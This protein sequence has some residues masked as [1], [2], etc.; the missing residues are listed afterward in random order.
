MAKV[1]LDISKR[2]DITCRRGDSFSLELTLKDS[3]GNAINLHG[4]TAATFN[5]LV[6]NGTVNAISAGA[7]VLDPAALFTIDPAITD[8][9]DTTSDTATG[10]VKF[11]ATSTDM[12]LVPAGRYKYDIQ[13]IDP[14][15]SVDGASKHSTILTGFFVVNADNS[16]LE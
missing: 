5:M 14:N 1:N 9:A 12:A 10:I 16:N 15:T 2:L 6:S 4:G 3:S 13:Y 7:L 8:A 11:E